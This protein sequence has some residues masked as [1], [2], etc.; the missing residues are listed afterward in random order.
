MTSLKHLHLL[1]LQWSVNDQSTYELMVHSKIDPFLFPSVFCL[2]RKNTIIIIIPIM[3]PSYYDTLL[4]CTLL[5]CT[6]LLWTL[7]LCTLLLHTPL[8][9]PPSYYTPS[10][11]GLRITIY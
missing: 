11:S 7:L 2:E 5:L 10:L 1:V 4:L 8:I 3:P 9:M 6:L